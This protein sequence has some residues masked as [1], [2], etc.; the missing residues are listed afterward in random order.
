ME[1][2]PP[3]SHEGGRKE[4][5]GRENMHDSYTCVCAAHRALQLRAVG[6]VPDD[7]VLRR[8]DAQEVQV[9]GPWNAGEGLMRVVTVQHPNVILAQQGVICRDTQAHTNTGY[10]TC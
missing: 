6:C 4:C 2:N 1:R 7:V 8:R 10:L 3:E 9:I 5:F